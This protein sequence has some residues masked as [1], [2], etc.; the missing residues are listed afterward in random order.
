MRREIKGQ[1]AFS[2][3]EIAVFC[4][5]I[6]LLLN[7]GIPV[8][9]GVHMLYEEIE[10]K[11]TKKVLEELE[12]QVRNNVPLHEALEKTKAFP[13][14]MVQMVRIGAYSGKLEDV[15][16]FLSIYYERETNV[17]ISIKNAVRSPLIVFVMASVIMLL[18]AW[19]ILPLF[20]TM[21]LELNAEISQNAQ[22]MMNIGLTL[23]T[24]IGIISCVIMVLILL[25]LLIRNTPFGTRIIGAVIKKLELT[26]KL[27]EELSIGRFLSG[28]S[29]MISSGMDMEKSLE[30]I[31]KITTHKKVKEK[32]GRCYKLVSKEK[33]PIE[34]A[35]RKT[36]LMKGMESSLLT[37]AGKTGA[38]DTV[39][40]K[41]SEQYQIKITDKLHRVSTILETSLIIF[42]TV[43]IGVVLLAV[44]LP[45]VSMISSIG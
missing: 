44:M 25:L 21:F 20:Q 31:E 24:V 10:D 7:S 14:Y 15:M 8:H 34:E 9:D 6:A 40:A 41:L 23:G 1:K 26:N 30:M 11:P 22:T 29:L 4:E 33:V 39:F 17:K 18:M 13:A 19:R 12:E 36:E 28:M 16:H 43:T 5:Q 45:L 38:L 42:L 37:I 35:V 27:S 3:E 2:S 32:I